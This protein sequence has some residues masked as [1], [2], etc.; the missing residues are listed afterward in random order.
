MLQDGM[1]RIVLIAAFAGTLSLCVPTIEPAKA[2]PCKEPR[3]RKEWYALGGTHV[4]DIATN[5]H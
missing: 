1:N 4:A 2:V 5:S 3:I